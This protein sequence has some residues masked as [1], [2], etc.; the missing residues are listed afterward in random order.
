MASRSNMAARSGCV[1]HRDI[2]YKTE[3]KYQSVYF[4]YP[5]VT[6]HTYSGTKR[7]IFQ[8]RNV[9]ICNCNR[10][11]P[12]LSLIQWY[13]WLQRRAGTKKYQNKTK[14][15]KRERRTM[16]SCGCAFSHAQS[17]R[18]ELTELAS[19]IHQFPLPQESHVQHTWDKQHVW[20]FLT[21]K[22]R[23]KKDNSS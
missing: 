14:Q 5:P 8:P 23:K 17:G 20:F 9:Q 12:L 2:I 11:L 10:P 6:K 13:R 18:E 22:K 19:L 16:T 7:P 3:G 15:K 21:E 4:V 1:T